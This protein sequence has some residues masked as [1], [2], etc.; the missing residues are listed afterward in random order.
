MKTRSLVAG[1]LIA[2]LSSVVVPLRAHHSHA[3]FDGSKETEIT[4]TVA[5]VR[6]A[7]P[8]VYVRVDATHR[9]GKPLEPTQTWAIEMSTT[10][11]MTQRGITPDLL[12]IGV[13]ISIKVNPLFS[14]GFSGNYTNMVMVN[15]VKNS[16]TDQD[17]KPIA[18]AR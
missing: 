18:A 14:G 7:N 10:V 6:F 17:W 15:G 9:D 16:S 12:K 2:I 8:H 5:A 11:N 4:G 1:A 13:P 3:M